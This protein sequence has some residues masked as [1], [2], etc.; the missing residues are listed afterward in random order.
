MT[1]KL[2]R[3]PAV[4][5]ILCVIV[6][7]LVVALAVPAITAAAGPP[8]GHISLPAL[9]QMPSKFSLVSG[10]IT[11]ISGNTSM[12]VALKHGAGNLAVGQAVVVMPGLLGWPIGLLTLPQMSSKIPMV[13]SGNITQI[14]G[15]TTMTIALKSGAGTLAVG[16]AVIVMRNLLGCPMNLFALPQTPSKTP[17][18]VLGNITQILGNITQK[19]GNLTQIFGNATMTNN[20]KNG[21]G[22]SAL[23]QLLTGMPS[24]PTLLQDLEGILSNLN[25][26]NQ[27]DWSGGS[28]QGGKHSK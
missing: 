16:R 14:S 3:K 7:A 24:M 27:G 2:P 6:I 10:N 1:A 17:M 18:G 4:I 20:L 22:T 9:P 13:V 23:G 12:T 26:R 5:G 25:L 15:N 11:Q 19:W 8:R 28:G 21:A